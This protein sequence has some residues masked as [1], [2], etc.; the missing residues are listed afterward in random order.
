MAGGNAVGS[1]RG[2]VSTGG[3]VTGVLVAC[4]LGVA[5]SVAVATVKG[6]A[7]G[8]GLISGVWVRVGV[9]VGGN[10]RGVGVNVG[11]KGV[12]GGRV[13]L[14]CDTGVVW[15]G[16]SC[17]ARNTA[18]TTVKMTTINVPAPISRRCAAEEDSFPFDPIICL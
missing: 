8:V 4:G 6:V 2:G 17:K 13:G 5:V 10:G 3:G 9:G 14:S 11:I 1:G 12:G 15:S 18:P 16:V 7:V